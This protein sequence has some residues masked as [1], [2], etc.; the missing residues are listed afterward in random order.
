MAE[1]ASRGSSSP[2]VSNNSPSEPQSIAAAGLGSPQNSVRCVSSILNFASR[3][4][5]QAVKT[6]T[7]SPGYPS[8]SQMPGIH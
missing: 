2:L 7:T 5:A 3:S 4:A 6:K 1:I 8:G